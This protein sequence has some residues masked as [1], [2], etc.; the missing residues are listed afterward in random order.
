MPLERDWLNLLEAIA[1]KKG[2]A[3]SHLRQTSFQGTGEGRG[4]CGIDW[5]FGS[6]DGDLRGAGFYFGFLDWGAVRRLMLH[7]LILAAGQD[8][9]YVNVGEAVK[10]DQ[11]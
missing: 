10:K 4:V 11:E 6:K 3:F 9:K 7:L 5:C 1:L 8:A 2:T